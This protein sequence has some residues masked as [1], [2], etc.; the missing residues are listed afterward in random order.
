MKSLSRVSFYFE[1]A[2]RH[3]NYSDRREFSVFAA[4]PWS[5]PQTV[6]PAVTGCR[7]AGPRGGCFEVRTPRVCK[8][9][10]WAVTLDPGPA[11]RAKG[12]LCRSPQSEGRKLVNREEAAFTSCPV[13]AGRRDFPDICFKSL[14]QA[15]EMETTQHVL[16]SR[17]ETFFVFLNNTCG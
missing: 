1:G 9:C 13:P 7:R 4:G 15:G 17:Q 3:R 16:Y 10:R 2:T 5:G 12:I 8:L 14:R 6:P 11:A